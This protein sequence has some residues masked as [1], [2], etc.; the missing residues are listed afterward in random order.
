HAGEAA[1]AE[2]ER[3]DGGNRKQI[4]QRIGDH[5]DDLGRDERGNAR[6]DSDQS[7]AAARAPAFCRIAALCARRDL[8]TPRARSQWRQTTGDVPGLLPAR[9]APFLGTRSPNEGA[10]PWMSA[11]AA[12][13]RSTRAGSA[14]RRAFGAKRR[15]TSSGSSRPRRWSI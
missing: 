7:A 5:S 4:E 10:A 15:G 6:L 9:R 1:L 2:T 3:G 12:I 8:Q 11:R 14:T 13:T